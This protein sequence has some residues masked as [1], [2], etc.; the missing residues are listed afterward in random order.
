MSLYQRR[1]GKWGVRYRDEWGVTHRKPVGTREAAAAVE[2]QIRSTTAIQKASLTNFQRGASITVEEAAQVYLAQVAVSPYTLAHMT[3]RIAQFTRSIGTSELAQ[4]S[5]LLLRKWQERR[6]Q[7]LSLQTLWRDHKMY[8]AWFDWLQRNW[9]IASNPWKLGELHIPKP[10][11]TRAR[12]LNYAEEADLLS[13][14]TP[15]TKL[16]FLLALD[17]GLSLGEVQTL[18]RHGLDFLQRQI[19][20]TRPKTVRYRTRPRYIPMTERLAQILTENSRH[21]APDALVCSWAGKEMHKGNDF[22]RQQRHHGAPAIRFHDLRH[23]FATRLQAV[24][25]NPFVVAELLGHALPRYT[26]GAGG[27]PILTTTA[28]YVHPTPAQLQEAINAMQQSTATALE[29][30]ARAEGPKNQATL[31]QDAP[32]ANR[33]AGSTPEMCGQEQPEEKEE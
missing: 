19:A 5:P 16:R 8:R 13:R 4:V 14:L 31:P 32:P 26:F 28:D 23:T 10:I 18:R 33:P 12:I 24:C 20:T 7:T 3:Q 30:I 1:D 9:Y 11:E 22:L 6:R 17:A 21:L 25:P 27:R 2:Q 15:R 29:E